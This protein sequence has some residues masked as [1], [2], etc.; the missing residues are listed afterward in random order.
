MPLLRD[1]INHAVMP[2]AARAQNV[3]TV[4]EIDLKTRFHAMAEQSAGSCL[5]VH[6]LQYPTAEGYDYRYVEIPRGIDPWRALESLR[7]PVIALDTAKPFADIWP[8]AL[9]GTVKHP[10]DLLQQPHF[11]IPDYRQDPSIVRLA[12]YRHG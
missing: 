8:T 2:S 4:F 11:A 1:I 6:L 12:D 7:N 5:V 10:R 3:P 9:T